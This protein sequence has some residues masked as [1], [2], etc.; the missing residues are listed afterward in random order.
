MV[1]SSRFNNGPEKA[2]SLVFPTSYF[3]S[4]PR[5]DRQLS[6]VKTSDEVRLLLILHNLLELQREPGN[7]IS[8][9]RIVFQQGITCSLAISS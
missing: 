1:E 7:R 2:V 6:G 5:D 9:Q 4:T 8:H 3:Q